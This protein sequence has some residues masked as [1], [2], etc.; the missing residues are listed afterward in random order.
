[1]TA[2][3]ARTTPAIACM[4][5]IQASPCTDRILAV[6]QRPFTSGLRLWHDRGT[7]A[8]TR[9]AL[10]NSSGAMYVHLHIEH[11]MNVP[12]CASVLTHDYGYRACDPSPQPMESLLLAQNA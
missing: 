11:S 1:M 3:L 7:E 8:T 12:Y 5:Q 6:H 9:L 4:R 2:T 10:D